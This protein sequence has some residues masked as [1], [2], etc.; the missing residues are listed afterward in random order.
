[1]VTRRSRH[2]CVLAALVAVSTAHTAMAQ[3]PGRLA[4]SARDETGA[5]L[6]NVAITLAGPHGVAGA[7]VSAAALAKVEAPAYVADT[8][9][10]A[11]GAFE[12]RDLRPGLYQ[13]EA[14]RKGFEVTSRTVQI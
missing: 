6:A 4:G 12:F 9:S 1:M 5:L 13:I 14:A 11:S 7:D 10:N 3:Q 8:R 2:I